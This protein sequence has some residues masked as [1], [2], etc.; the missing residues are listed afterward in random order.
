MSLRLPLFFL[1]ALFLMA[2]TRTKIIETDYKFGYYPLQAGHSLIYS[3]DSIIYNPVLQGG[4]D[5][6][7]YEIRD[8]FESSFTNGSGQKVWRVER[9]FRTSA[10]N[11]WQV[12]KI[13]TATLSG[14]R[15]ERTEDNKTFIS[16]VFPVET[17]VEW[18]GNAYITSGPDLDFYAD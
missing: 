13:W 14:N 4:R 11:P 7:S 18:N 15:L 9:S 8:L 3:V 12:Q 16:L 1:M 17:G 6:L 10:L 2:C 5:T